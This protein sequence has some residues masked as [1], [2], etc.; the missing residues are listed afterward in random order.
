MHLNLNNA[1]ILVTGGAGFMGS[2]FIR[3]ALKQEAFAGH[4][5]NLDL[6]TYAGHLENLD[7]I[8]GD[9]RYTFFHG[10][11]R[12]QPLLEKIHEERP[13]TAIVHFAAE[14]HVDR[15]IIDPDAFIQTNVVGTYKLLEFVRKYPEI[16]FHHISTDEVYG[17]LGNEGTFTEN[18]PY[19]PNSPYSASKASSDHL[20]RSYGMTYKLSTTTSHA[21]NNYGPGQYPEKLI[22]LMIQKILEKK[23]LP[24]YGAGENIREWLFVEDHARAIWTILDRGKKGEVYNIGGG[25]EMKNIDLL[26]LLFEIMKE[27]TGEKV[28]EKLIAFVEDRPGHDFRY[29]MDG[30]KV[31]QL[32]YRPIWPL[33]AGLRETIRSMKKVC[34]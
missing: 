13:I 10:D 28:D 12:D 21:S 27:V 4:L 16:H 32:G 24:V 30:A 1:H 2:A 5:S 8:K 29:A 3:F 17:A 22:P 15:S 25:N 19:R 6:L 26:H 14:T 7:S 33:K 23:E 11:I 31:E 9:E 20:V 34:V 18:S